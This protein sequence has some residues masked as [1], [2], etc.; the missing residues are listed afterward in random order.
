MDKKIIVTI[1]REYGSGGREIGQKLAEKIGATF[2]DKELISL[3]AK[4]SGID[5]DLFANADE[6]PTN[7][8]WSSLAF[9]VGSFGNRVPTMNDMPM[10]DRLFLIQSNVIKKVAA[11][12][13]CVIV[14]RCADYILDKNPDAVHLFIHSNDE[15]KLNRIIHSYGVP[16]EAAKEAMKKTDKRRAAY[17]DYYVGEKWGQIDHYD[18]A[19]DSSFLGIDKTVDLIVQFIQ[20]KR[21]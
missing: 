6:K 1:A 18:L 4:E 5:E 10:N 16:E 11:E 20:M 7:P 15:D 2:Y 14:G 19:I 8:F 17:Y 3:A 13:S 9:N 21:G 12:G